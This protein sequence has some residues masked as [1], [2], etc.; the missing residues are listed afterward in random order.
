[1][2]SMLMIDN[3]DS[4]TYN[5]VQGFKSLGV[6][7]NVFRNNAIGVE[8][9]K[10]LDPDYLVIS[11]GPGRPIDAGISID[12]IKAFSSYV[13]VSYTHLTLPTILLV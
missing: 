4:F 13:P 2:K 8:E 11:P 3:F 7:V 5:L 12:L 1:M 6:E 9:A 10:V